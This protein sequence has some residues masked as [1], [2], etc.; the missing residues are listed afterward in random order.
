MTRRSKDL[1]SSVRRS[2]GSSLT[3]GAII[4]REALRLKKAE[5][6]NSSR[7]VR[8]FCL[9]L[10]ATADS[11]TDELTTA[12]MHENRNSRGATREDRIPDGTPAPLVLNSGN[13]ETLISGDTYR[14]LLALI[15]AIRKE[16]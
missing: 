8:W 7:E 1:M 12:R 6:P 2:Q 9:A 14:Q 11:Q 3:R 5:P 15:G 10:H 4:G 16:G 13:C